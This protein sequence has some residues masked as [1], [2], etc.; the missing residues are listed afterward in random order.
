L[1]FGDVWQTKLKYLNLKLNTTHNLK[2]ATWNLARPK[3]PKN[4]ILAKNTIIMETIKLLDADIFILTETNS[5]I[6]LLPQYITSVSSDILPVNE[7][8][9]GAKYNPGENRTTIWSKF[10][11]I[12]KL[13]VS[14]SYTNVCVDLKAPFGIIR[15]YGAIIG[16]QGQKK[17][18]FTNDLNAT[19]DDCKVLSKNMNFLLAGDFNLSFSDNF[20]PHKIAKQVLESVFE[21][22]QLKNFTAILPDN[23]DHIVGSESLVNFCG[24]PS[25][26]II[27]MKNKSISDHSCVFV[28]FPQ[29]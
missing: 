22:C 27:R 11:M 24:T 5:T 2:I 25:T 26:D 28:T 13:A 7:I 16:I 15:V 21:E 4:G 23:I 9:D 17:P 8:F 3:I 6:S 19:V 1:K 29:Q 14:N 20:Y 18:W 10:P 12:Q